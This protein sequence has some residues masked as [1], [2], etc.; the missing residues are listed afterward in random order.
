M[1]T[2]N[3]AILVAYCVMCGLF[4]LI[5]PWWH[6]YRGDV[7][8]SFITQPPVPTAYI[9]I[10]GVIENLIVVSIIAAVVYFLAKKLI[11]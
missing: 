4:I 6:P 1:E 10:S 2:K 7:G 8:Y 9:V 11:K 3:K 5:V